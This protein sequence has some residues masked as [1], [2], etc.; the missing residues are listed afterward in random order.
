MARV[1][2]ASQC[3]PAKF[4]QSIS[5][6]QKRKNPGYDK[7]CWDVTPKVPYVLGI[8]QSL[9]RH[10]SGVHDAGPHR[11]PDEAQV[12]ERAVLGAAAM[13]VTAQ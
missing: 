11:E 7:Q 2:V 3:V 5:W 9:C 8:P 4:R 1:Q 6:R 12:C 10:D 13:P